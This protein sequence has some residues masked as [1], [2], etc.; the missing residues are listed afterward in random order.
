MLKQNRIKVYLKYLVLILISSIYA[1]LDYGVN[2]ELR[3]SDGEIEETNFFENYFDINL[4]YKDLYVYTLLIHKDPSL[5][6]SSTKSM[7]DILNSIYLEYSNIYF[8][9]C[10]AFGNNILF[11]R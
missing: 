8:S 4:Y 1:N 2:Y 3:Y 9:I 6:G 7:E 10:I 5:I 11:S